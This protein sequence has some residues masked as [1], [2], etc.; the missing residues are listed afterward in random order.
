MAEDNP[1]YLAWL[2]R[3]PCAKCNHPEPSHAHHHTG[4]RGK[5]QRASDN[6]AMPLCWRCHRLFHDAAGPFQEW[7]KEQ[8]ISWQDDLVARY[9]GIYQDANLF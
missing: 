9:R 6:D 7:T 2:R 8:R 5:S 3:Q 4:R 1:T